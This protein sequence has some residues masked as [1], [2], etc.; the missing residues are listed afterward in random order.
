MPTDKTTGKGLNRSRFASC[1]AI[2]L[3]VMI[4]ACSCG[5]DDPFVVVPPDDDDDDPIV[6]IPGDTTPGTIRLNPGLQYQTI[7]GWYA[8]AQVGEFECPTFPIYRDELYNRMINELGLNRI[9]LPVR[10]AS[11]H[12]V[13][14]FASFESG[15]LTLQQWQDTWFHAQNDN[16]DP[17]LIN[18]AGFHWGGLD[19]DIESI[20]L[21]ME[22]LLQARGER[23]V[24]SLTFTDTKTDPFEHKSAPHEYAEF[25]LALFQH[26]QSKYGFVPDIIEV[27]NEP[28][29]PPVAWTGA[30]QGR[31]IAAAGARLEA[32]GFTPRFA[33]PGTADM[34]QAPTMYDAAIQQTGAAKYVQEISYHRYRGATAAN[35]QKI[36]QR[37]TRDGLGAAMS[38]HIGSGYEDLHED[39][40]VGQATAWMQFAIALCGSGKTDGGGIYYRIDESNPANP[41]ITPRSR[42]P[43]LWQYFRYIREGALRIEATS[44][45]ADLDPVA[46]VHP[47]GLHTIVVKAA[48]AATFSVGTMPAGTY[49]ITY[50]TDSVINGV[51]ADV[52]LASR[53]KVT[54]AMPAK[55][56]VTIFGK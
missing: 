37:V 5:G 11:E 32:A 39:L 25:M 22:Q 54:V 48:N 55:G 6:P 29:T 35:L 17:N 47:S 18:P 19:S 3:V 51:L 9:K 36:A 12:P 8:T 46:F 50:V 31:A 43:F 1:F 52:T 38:E 41:V 56:V 21:P 27:V 34:A 33:V 40:K 49:G 7:S 10:S 16:G 44:A 14:H 26:M 20:A 30:Q 13:D 15:A 53:G 42:T 2:A 45:I 28:D 23:L 4:G 24:V